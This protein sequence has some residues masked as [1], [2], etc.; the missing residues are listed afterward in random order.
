MKFTLPISQLS[1]LFFSNSPIRLIVL[2]VSSWLSARE[3]EQTCPLYSGIFSS[4]TRLQNIS[5]ANVSG[6]GIFSHSYRAYTCPYL[7][8]FHLQ[9]FLRAKY[10][11]FENTSE[12]ESTQIFQ[13][14]LVEEKYKITNRLPTYNN[15]NLAFCHGNNASSR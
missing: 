1:P 10:E 11:K 8:L 13:E 14:K 12:I 9:I 3:A 15:F 5:Y 7:R 4:L 6:T 2:K